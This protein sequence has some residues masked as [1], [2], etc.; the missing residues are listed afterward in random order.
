MPAPVARRSLIKP[1]DLR[2]AERFVSDSRELSYYEIALTRRQ[3]VVTFGVLLLTQIGAFVAGVWLGL[4]RAAVVAPVAVSAPAQTLDV[5]PPTGS[6][7]RA[8]PAANPG[9]T[10]ASTAH[11][12]ADP[13][14][15]KLDFFADDQATAAPGPPPEPAAQSLAEADPTLEGDLPRGRPQKEP[16]GLASDAVPRA[17]ADLS[18]NPAA[19]ERPQAKWKRRVEVAREAEDLQQQFDRELP[20]EQAAGGPAA[21]AAPRPA[22]VEGRGTPA[23][24]APAPSGPTTFVV[25][26]L[27]TKEQGKA[28]EVLSQLQ[29]GGY[30]A[31]MTTVRQPN[32][33]MYRVRVGPY[34]DR[35][36][37]ERIAGELRQKFRVDTWITTE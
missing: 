3:V 35:T 11:E 27:S 7:E 31:V 17:A 13:A 22:T 4:G 37:A 6:G 34:R 9:D 24:K 29:D 33:V 20:A 32:T 30:P 16:E 10:A 15:E 21:A 18:G 19:E 14:L 25:Q 1:G 8:N 26:V 5:S 23:G 12:D 28:R 36:G 2:Y